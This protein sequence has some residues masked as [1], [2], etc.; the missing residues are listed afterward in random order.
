MWGLFAPWLIFLVLNLWGLRDPNSFP[1]QWLEI[2]HLLFLYFSIF[3]AIWWL[4]FII[5]CNSLFIMQTV[6][7]ELCYVS[8]SWQKCKPMSVMKLIIVGSKTP[9]HKIIVGTPKNFKVLEEKQKE[10]KICHFLISNDREIK[11]AV[12]NI[13][14]WWKCGKTRKI[15]KWMRIFK[16]LY[17]GTILWKMKC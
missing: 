10:G 13:K 12:R 17:D 1:F 3:H 2:L 5:Y 16:Q 11:K 14:K 6:N 15:K 8:I 7:L 9:T 4:L